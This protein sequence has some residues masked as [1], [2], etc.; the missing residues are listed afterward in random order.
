M[1][2]TGKIEVSLEPHGSH[3][4]FDISHAQ[5]GQSKL[6]QEQID[7]WGVFFFRAGFFHTFFD[8]F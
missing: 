5:I 8:H 4:D 3:G 1:Y 6:Q 7:Y 2:R